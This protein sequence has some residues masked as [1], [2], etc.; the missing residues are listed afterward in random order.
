MKLQS[1]MR[2]GICGAV[3]ALVMPLAHAITVS[4]PAP[5]LTFSC[6][7]LTYSAPNFNFVVDRDNT[8]NNTESYVSEIVD[9]A[10]NVLWRFT[11]QPSL[12][13]PPFGGLVFGNAGTL[14]Y[15]MAPAANPI[16]YRLVSLA[17]NGLPAQTAFSASGSCASLPPPAPAQTVVAVPTLGHWAMAALS[18]L[19][20]MLAG[21]T[22][23][24][25]L[26]L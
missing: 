26:R 7:E 14:S 15:T 19:L 11:N 16:T 24:R 6:T 3:V 13:P 2:A 20:L 12:G 25:H 10:G 17:G 5:T 18:M 4:G 9:G 21:R 8:G 22:M 1:S 23:R